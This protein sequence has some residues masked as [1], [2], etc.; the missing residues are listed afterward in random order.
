MSVME[1]LPFDTQTLSEENW[2]RYLGAVLSVCAA[3]GISD[4]ESAAIDNWLTRNGAPTGT[5]A[6][7]EK[8]IST[9]PES[10]SG[11]L[12]SATEFIAPYVVRDALRLASVDG[13]TEDERVSARSW[14]QALGVSDE[15]FDLIVEA[16]SCHDVATNAWRRALG[17]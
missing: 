4:A 6:A 2:A 10:L 11:Y 12:G 13:L 16:V 8:L 1:T 7:G 5:R 17:L 3:D 9:E 14:A 15:R